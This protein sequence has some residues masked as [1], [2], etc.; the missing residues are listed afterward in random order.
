MKNNSKIQKFVSS[1]FALLLSIILV[2]IILLIGLKFGVFND[3]VILRKVNESNYYNEVQKEL[4]ER[5]ERIILGT[6]MPDTVLTDVITLKRVYIGGKYYIEDT[7]AGK[8]P[9]IKTDS[10]KEQLSNN[11]SQYLTK[12]RITRTKE[13]DSG[14]NEVIGEVEL[15][16]KRGIQFQFIHYIYEYKAYYSKLVKII[17]PVL[18]IG[19]AIICYFLIRLQKYK[20]QGIRYIAYAVMSSTI[21][22]LLTTTIL[23]VTKIYEKINVSPGYYNTFLINYFK[24]DIRVF[25]YLGGLSALLSVLL[26]S[27]VGYVKATLE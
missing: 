20:H 4:T 18:I 10:I 16:Y 8:N 1:I 9:V 7:L 12:E 13:L 24:W 11:I 22:T 5:T 14:I 6:G 23:L 26:I 21:I 25:L 17:L 27:L 19:V 3:N 15:E 2:V